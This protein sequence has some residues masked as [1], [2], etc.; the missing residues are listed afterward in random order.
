MAARAE[1][2]VCCSAGA[3]SME[4]QRKMLQL[5]AADY[6]DA[7]SLRVRHLREASEAEPVD[8][9]LAMLLRRL[10]YVAARLGDEISAS[11]WAWVESAIVNGN[12]SEEGGVSGELY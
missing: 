5:A 2:R 8:H 7:L 1:L 10:A 4:V 11:H 6:S 3:R 12:A 9:A